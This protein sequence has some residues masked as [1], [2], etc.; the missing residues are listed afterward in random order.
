MDFARWYLQEKAADRHFAKSVLF[1]DEA[2]FSLKGVI[3][4]HNLLK[5]ADEN[6][7]AIHLHAAQRK[8]SVNVWAVIVGDCLLGTY[9][10][11][12]RLNG[13]THLTFLQEVLP[14][15]FNNLSMPICRRIQ[16]QPD[17]APT[18]VRPHLHDI[19]PCGWI[20]RGGPI[21]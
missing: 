2:V 20:G 10:L 12:E 9:F 4:C 17:G 15:M 1:T 7:Y 8:F 19:I 14:D 16:F 6:P 11:P 5:W 3:N 21:A 18:H 13:S